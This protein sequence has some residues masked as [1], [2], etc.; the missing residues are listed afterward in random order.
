MGGDEFMFVLPDLSAPG[1]AATIANNV[2][3][4]I[5]REMSVGGHTLRVTGSIGISIFPEDGDSVQ[6]LMRRADTAMFRSKE[7]GE[8]ASHFP[9]RDTR[10]PWRRRKHPHDRSEIEMQATFGL[11]KFVAPEFIFGTG[12]MD[13]AGQYARNFGATRILLVSDRGFA[14]PGGR[15]AFPH[16]STRWTSPG[17]CT[18]TSRRTPRISRSTR[19]LTSSF[20][21]GATSS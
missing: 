12:A 1:E 3:E 20:P 16:A 13:L 7:R 21:N 6:T 15:N 14:R 11:R 17:S 4:S 18:N 19:A 9:T 10:T 2:I 8:T 5:N